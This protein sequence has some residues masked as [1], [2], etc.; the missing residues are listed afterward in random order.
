ML[1]RFH[2]SDITTVGHYLGSLIA[3]TGLLMLVPFVVA[4]A[5]GETASA[6]DFLFSLGLCLTVGSLMRLL[7]S[8]GLDRRR[9][10]LL[11]GISWIVVAFVASIPMFMS[12][13]YASPLNAM[14][15]ALSSLTTTGTSLAENIDAFSYSQ[16]TWHVQLTHA[17]GLAV[18]AIAL[19]FGFFGEGGFSS[20]ATST[21]RSDVL[22][23]DL[24]KTGKFILVVSGTAILLGTIGIAGLTLF[25]GYNPVDALMNGLWLAATAVSTGGFVPH[26]SSLIYYHF[27]GIDTIVAVLMVFGALNFGIYIVALRGKPREGFRNSE[28]RAFLVW[29][30][31]MTIFITSVLTAD[32]IYT[33]IRGIL[34]HGT[35]MVVSASTTSGMQ[36]VYPQQFGSALPGNVLILLML[37]VFIGA[38]SSSAS[39]GVKFIHVVQVMQWF[40]YT[41]MKALLPDNAHITIRYTHFGPKRLESNNAMR[42]MVIFILYLVFGALGS[43]LFIA[44]GNDAFKSIFESLSY[45]CNCGIQ[46]GLSSPDMGIDLKLMAMFQM[47]AGRLEFIALFAA[48]AGL[49]ISIRPMRVVSF[50]GDMRTNKTLRGT[51]NNHPWQRLHRARK[52]KERRQKKNE[53]KGSGTQLAIALLLSAGLAFGA[54]PQVAFADQDNGPEVSADILTADTSLYR[55]MTISSL[56]S[57]SSRLDGTRVSITGE[58]MGNP[59]RSIEGGWWVNLKE[60]DAMIGVLVGDSVIDRIENYGGYGKTGDT[61]TVTGIYRYA[62]GKHSGELDVHATSL[63]VTEKGSVTEIPYSPERLVLGCMFILIGIILNVVHHR[64]RGKSR[65]KRFLLGL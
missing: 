55:E 32:G 42:A 15:D 48:L 31:I 4:L 18:I 8:H 6:V 40:R 56:V 20:I 9:S 62:C 34:D 43:M 44:H 19:Y 41:T 52:R 65:I 57:S 11:T 12:G 21:G 7:K 46:T 60:D 17:G 50:F 23:A 5:F 38:S 22:S 33:S 51:N 16:I 49:V 47:W 37:C 64:I 61:V 36:T 39:G 54:V 14:F 30:V 29:V 2:W 27:F 63:T 25:L 3:L 35:F 13:N 28:T 26:T 1:P 58:A 24:R 53:A 59:I 45:V 10:L